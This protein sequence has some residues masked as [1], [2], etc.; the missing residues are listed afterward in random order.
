MDLD[1]TWYDYNLE[2]GGSENLFGFEIFKKLPKMDFCC[3]WEN[4]HEGKIGNFLK[5]SK[6]N[7]FSEPPTSRL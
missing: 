7:R 1:E 2:V 3:F 6:Q 5:I 4:D